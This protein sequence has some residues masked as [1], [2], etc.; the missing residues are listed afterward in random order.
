MNYE[1]HQLANRFMG[2]ELD[3]W[4]DLISWSFLPV[5]KQLK[6]NSIC[7]TNTFLYIIHVLTWFMII[8]SVRQDEKKREQK[9]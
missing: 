8:T 7:I 1:H 9:M 6:N 2:K 5:V 3:S 4:H